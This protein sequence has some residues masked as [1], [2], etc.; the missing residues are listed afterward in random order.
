[1]MPLDS[2]HYTEPGYHTFYVASIETADARTGA[3]GP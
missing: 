1:M 2:T 3:D